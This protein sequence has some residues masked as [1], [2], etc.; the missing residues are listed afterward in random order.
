MSLIEGLESDNGRDNR[1]VAVYIAALAVLLAICTI[2]GDNA[3]KNVI[4]ASIDVTDTWAFFQAR[5]I[6]QQSLRLAADE[7]EMR[8]QEPGLPE[9][10]RKA[11][12][13][14]I[15]SYRAKADRYQS[16][17]KEGD[18]KKELMAKARKLEAERTLALKQ[19]PY[20]DYGGGLLQIAIVLA[21]ASL[22]LG[23]A[24]L[25]WVSYGAGVLGVLLMLNAFTLLV[26]LPLLG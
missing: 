18:G 19:G 1:L 16:D 11:M 13:K 15:A 6:R 21:S 4:V 10:V 14:K 2:G 20:F 17:P 24:L 9:A 12:Q 23:G 26:E 3:G 25:L 22:I 7:L 8:L 5:N